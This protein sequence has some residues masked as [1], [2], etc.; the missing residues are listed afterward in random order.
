MA[1]KMQYTVIA[2]APG[3]LLDAPPELDEVRVFFNELKDQEDGRGWC[4]FS[5]DRHTVQRFFKE[6]YALM[7][8]AER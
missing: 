4:V 2:G 5:P 3:S 6:R 8:L 1:D 7:S